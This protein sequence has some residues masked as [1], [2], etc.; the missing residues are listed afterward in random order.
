MGP[1][2][3]PLALL[4]AKG[5]CGGREGFIPDRGPP[6]FQVPSETGWLALTFFVECPRGFPMV[7]HLE[8][9]PDHSWA[10]WP[11]IKAR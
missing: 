3:S 7:S 10:L 1:G 6:F 9:L 5:S 4:V 8:H 11:Q 2:Q